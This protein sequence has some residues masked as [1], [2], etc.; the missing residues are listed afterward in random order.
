MRAHGIDRVGTT[1]GGRYA[2]GTIIGRGGTSTVYEARDLRLGHEVAVKVLSIDEET[3]ERRMKREARVAAGLRHPNVCLVTDF[4]HIDAQTPYM[5][6]ERLVGR[7][8]AAHLR[9]KRVLD[10]P[11]AL[12]IAKQVLS[13]LHVAHEHGIVHRDIKPENLFLAEVVGQPPLVK[14]LDFG[15]ASDENEFGLTAHGSQPG[16]LAYMSPEQ[17]ASYAEIDGRSDIYSCATVLFQCLTG[18]LPF[19]AQSPRELKSKIIR[20]GAPPISS[21][22]PDVPYVVAR[23]IEQALRVEREGRFE[24]ALDFLLV[25]D[26]RKELPQDTSDFVD[27]AQMIKRSAFEQKPKTDEETVPM[28]RS[29]LRQRR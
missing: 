26:G 12:D 22:R 24:T 8:L 25:L 9:Q 7:S 27:T 29:P 14:V 17:A 19:E 2:L 10:V 20:G 15:V 23:A 18:K 11:E 4:G 16:T 3:A 1:I 6:M 13:V 5:V 21:L 28:P